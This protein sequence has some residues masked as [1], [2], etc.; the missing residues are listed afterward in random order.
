MKIN[1][2]VRLKSK[3]F[4]VTFVPALMAFIV[5]VGAMFGVDLT[6]QTTQVTAIIMA[7]LTLLASLGVVIDPTT[8]GVNDSE[9]AMQYEVPKDAELETVFRPEDYTKV[10]VETD[11]IDQEV[12]DYSDGGGTPYDIPESEHDISNDEAL[13]EGE[14][15]NGENTETNRY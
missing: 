15:F 9:M 4:W 11:V 12:P 13:V 10:S 7:I 3:A 6:A 5:S 1:W 2:K 8:K 14:D